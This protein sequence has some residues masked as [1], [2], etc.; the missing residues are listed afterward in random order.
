MGLENVAEGK[1]ERGDDERGRGVEEASK[2]TH[3]Q[4]ITQQG[5]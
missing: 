4:S 3:S 2:H 5:R 1:G